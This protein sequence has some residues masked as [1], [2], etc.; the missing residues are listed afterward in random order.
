M[1]H[2]TARTFLKCRWL[3]TD[4]CWLEGEERAGYNRK[5]SK[6][7]LRLQD[8][9]MGVSGNSLSP[10]V[11]FIHSIIPSSLFGSFS[12]EKFLGLLLIWFH[13][14][15]VHLFWQ[16]F[17]T[18]WL[19]SPWVSLKSFRAFLSHPLES[20]RAAPSRLLCDSD[21]LT[22]VHQRE[23][24]NSQQYSIQVCKNGEGSVILSC[25]DTSGYES[26]WTIVAYELLNCIDLV[27][28][29]H[30]SSC[31]LWAFFVELVIVI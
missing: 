5:H 28:L 27:L 8:K 1:G 18:D 15:H 6:S 12:M 10:G 24:L 16:I 25:N 20:L 3:L 29:H 14:H 19:A 23:V 22:I 9:E 17:L 11:L 2:I 26:S 13:F 4:R 7:S 30:S 21:R 31:D